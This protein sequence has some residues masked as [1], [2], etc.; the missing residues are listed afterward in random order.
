VSARSPG[1]RRD[2]LTL[3]GAFVRNPARTGTIAPSSPALARAMIRGLSLDPGETIV[4]FGPGTGP[5]TAEIR[6]ILPAPACYVGFEIEPRLVALL[7]AR[8]PELLVV[9]GSAEQAPR[10]LAE[11]G[12][13]RVRA[14]VCGLPFASLAPRV[15]DGIIRAFDAL[16]GPGGE[17]RTF[18][19]V[20]SFA[21][22]TTVRFLRRMR[23]VFGA[24]TRHATVLRNVPPACV[25]RWTR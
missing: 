14:V 10:F 8:Y 22:P 17:I 23:D 1:P 3:L 13:S 7:R 2:T 20:H 18:Q 15:Q 11:A 4:E 5:F 6:R 19:Y 9:Q 24:H 12:R 21:L 25:L 16:I